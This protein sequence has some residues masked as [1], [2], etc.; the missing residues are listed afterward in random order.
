[1]ETLSSS[2]SSYSGRKINEVAVYINTKLHE[3]AKVL[4]SEFHDSLSRYHNLNLNDFVN[5][6]DPSEADLV[7][8][9][10]KKKV[11]WYTCNHA[12]C[13]PHESAICVLLFCTNNL[14][15]MPL[16]VLLTEPVLCHGGSLELV[17]VLNRVGAVAS[18]DTCNRL[19]THV[20]QQRILRGIK[21]ELCPN[22]LTVVSIDNI[23]ILQ[24]HAIVSGVDATRSWHGTSMQCVQPLPASCTSSNAEVL[25]ASNTSRKHVASSPIPSPIPMERCKRRRRTLTE[26]ASLHTNMANPVGLLS[27]CGELNLDDIDTTDYPSS[28]PNI[29]LTNFLPTVEEK[30]SMTYLHEGVF[31]CILLKQAQSHLECSVLPGISSLLNCIQQQKE[32]KEVSNVVYMQILSERADSKDTWEICTTLLSSSWSRGGSLSLVT[33]RRMTSYNPCV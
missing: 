1:M 10:P 20:V 30:C 4:I 7:C 16:H 26:L 5:N 32:D 21:P 15:S 33:P 25:H 14:C 8:K 13:L 12:S 11:L 3:Q 31:R 29:S 18:L 19:A 24:S 22:T 9:L 2:S 23:D 27:H 17:K 6:L 28:R